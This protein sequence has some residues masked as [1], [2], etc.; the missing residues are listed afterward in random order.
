MT[1]VSLS[2]ARYAPANSLTSGTVSLA[3]LGEHR[4]AVDALPLNHEIPRSGNAMI[5]PL[6]FESTISRGKAALA[7]LA[8]TANAGLDFS[9]QEN[10][11]CHGCRHR[12]LFSLSLSGL[13]DVFHLGLKISH[14]RVHASEISIVLFRNLNAVT[15]SQLHHDI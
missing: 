9:E 3:R 2:A 12:W 11:V 13:D 1:I 5:Q 6:R 8:S 14:R 4:G 7:M 15:L 10:L